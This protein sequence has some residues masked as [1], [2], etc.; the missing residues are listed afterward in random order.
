MN[1]ATNVVSPSA[2]RACRDLSTKLVER[3]MSILITKTWYARPPSKMLFATAEPC[4]R[5]SRIPTKPAPEIC[6]TVETTSDVIKNPSINRGETTEYR[7][8]VFRI[9]IERIVYIPAAK[10]HRRRNNKEVIEHEVYQNI[11]I[12]L[13]R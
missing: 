4:L 9:R 3:M 13:G 11:R 2:L 7:L 6:M 1:T 10:K 8:P 12:F 5:D